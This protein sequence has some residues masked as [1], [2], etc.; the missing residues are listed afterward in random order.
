MQGKSA[1]KQQA[2]EHLNQQQIQDIRSLIQNQQKAAQGQSSQAQKQRAHSQFQANQAQNQAAFDGSARAQGQPNAS[3][4]A[5]GVGGPQN[6]YNNQ[7]TQKTR[8]QQVYQNGIVM[9]GPAGQVANTNVAH[10][11]NGSFVGAGGLGVQNY[12]TNDFKK[13]IRP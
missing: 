6:K 9:A 4:T 5:T 12:T 11:N 2:A 1:G 13:Q 10:N 7:S 8:N 3:I